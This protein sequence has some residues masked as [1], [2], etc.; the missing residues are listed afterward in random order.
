MKDGDSETCRWMCH[1]GKDGKDL[2]C[3]EFEKITGKPAE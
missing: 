1:Y 3:K 2:Y